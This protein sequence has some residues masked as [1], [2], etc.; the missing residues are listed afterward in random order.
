MWRVKIDDEQ[1]P[2]T[3]NCPPSYYVSGK[4]IYTGSVDLSSCCSC[5]SSWIN[6]IVAKD[7]TCPDDGCKVTVELDLPDSVTCYNYFVIEN[8]DSIQTPVSNIVNDTIGTY[9]LN[10]VN[11]GH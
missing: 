6:V 11:L 3:P 7:S 5:D 1:D 2:G 9:C 10:K 4:T 8:I